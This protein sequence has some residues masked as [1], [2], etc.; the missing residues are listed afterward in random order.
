MYE[1]LIKTKYDKNCSLLTN[2]NDKMMHLNITW[3]E[4]MNNTSYQYT[5]EFYIVII[6]LKK[7]ISIIK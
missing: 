6:K 7:K 2:I 5:F 3:F 1:K 4:N